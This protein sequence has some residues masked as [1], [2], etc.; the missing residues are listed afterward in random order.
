MPQQTFKAN[1][2]PPEK[3]I[4]FWFKAEGYYTKPSVLVAGYICG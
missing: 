1:G 2:E 3:T 4:L